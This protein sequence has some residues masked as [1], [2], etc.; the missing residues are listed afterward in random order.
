MSVSP[1]S[2]MID[3]LKNVVL[4]CEANG[5]R[6]LPFVAD[7]RRAVE[8]SASCVDAELVKQL[9]F[10]ADEEDCM[11]GVQQDFYH[12]G[13]LRTAADALEASVMVVGWE[14]PAEWDMEQRVFHAAGREDV[15][16]DV[17]ALVSLLWKQYCHAA[18]P[19][20]EDER[21]DAA[22]HVC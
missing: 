13:L 8:A 6:D 14:T 12:S 16:E 17:R 5:L 7:A 22:V 15:P 10:A 1:S 9:R 2:T 20:V 21:V 4:A 11:P 18:A 3:V 19:K